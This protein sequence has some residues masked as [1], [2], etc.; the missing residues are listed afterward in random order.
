MATI[1]LHGM[2]RSGHRLAVSAPAGAA[3]RRFMPGHHREFFAGLGY[4]FV[5]VADWKGFPLA[6]IV[7]AAPGFVSTCAAAD[8]PGRRVSTLLRHSPTGAGR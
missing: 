3:I 6:T 5:G 4:L 2:K 8:H 1:T 7:T